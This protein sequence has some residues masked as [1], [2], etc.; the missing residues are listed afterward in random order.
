MRC[1]A[2]VLFVATPFV[3]T[4]CGTPCPSTPLT[5]LASSPRFVLELTDFG[6]PGAMPSVPDG[7][8]SEPEPAPVVLPE[9]A[10]LAFYGGTSTLA[11]Q[12][13]RWI[14]TYALWQGAA[15]TYDARDG[16]PWS[17][18]AGRLTL[19]MRQSPSVAGF[20]LP[21]GALVHDLAV[22][23]MG[24]PEG[25]TLVDLAPVAGGLALASH[26]DG[27]LSVLD[28][29]DDG[30]LL[31]TLD[32]ASTVGTS[33]RAGRVA[34][35][36]AGTQAVV[37]LDVAER[38][39]VALVDVGAGAVSL[40]EL[41]GL[42]RCMEVAALP[43]DASRP[44]LQRVGVLCVG[45]PGESPEAPLGAGLAL[46]E[47][48]ADTPLTLVVGRPLSTLFPGFAPTHALVGLNGGW[49]AVASRGGPERLDALLAI[50]L[51]SDAGALL[52]QEAWT[53]QWGPG[54]G[55]GAF[56]PSA[57]ELVWPSVRSGLLRFRQVGT[58]SDAR[59]DALPSAR[60]PDCFRLAPR[61]ARYLP[62]P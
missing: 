42:R 13:E 60:T 47:A 57:S 3:A 54:L 21:S 38:G 27:R 51:E 25:D 14:D 31:R 20:A 45:E 34:P 19:L 23:V 56:D 4:G 46:L 18:P 5:P 36:G 11:V 49:V 28:L 29:R 9:Y 8:V 16:L 53:E 22:P 12:H 35:L 1:W 61:R 6:A 43:A 62:R 2:V 44:G 41:P 40:L 59:F 50:H 15:E 17:Q 33:V 10:T 48:D 52:W 37:G 39:L 58:R 26:R 55:E 30:A 24:T 7:G 32:V